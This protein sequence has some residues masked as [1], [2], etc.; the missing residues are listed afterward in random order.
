M[1]DAF[2][3]AVL[4]VDEQQWHRLYRAVGE[5]KVETHQQWAEICFVPNA[6]A[7][8]KHGPDYRF[9]AIREPLPEQLTLPETIPD[10]LSLPFP[11]MDMTTHCG[12]K[13][14]KITALV[15]NRQL[16]G[17]DLIR[18]YRERCGTGE[19]I[20]GVIKSDFAGGQLPSGLF[21]VNAAWWA[22]TLLALNLN[23]LM[24]RLVLPKT[25]LNRRIKAIRFHLINRAARITEQARSFLIR[26]N[27]SFLQFIIMA[28]MK[29]LQI[30]PAS[31]VA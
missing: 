9:L 3:R 24:K 30:G 5:D 10:Q 29:I 21:G 11:T 26:V 1:I 25:Y 28:R 31:W 20:H 19:M 13:R 17:D 4:E 22:I 16:P 7:T 14:F 8:K 15:T 12:S 27:R 2:K 6:L 18:W 23:T